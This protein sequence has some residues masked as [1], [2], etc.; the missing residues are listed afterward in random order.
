MAT[1]VTTDTL[2][3]LAGFR[4]GNGCAIS[5]TVDLDPSSTPTIPDV[6]TKFNSAIAQAEKLAEHTAGAEV[7]RRIHD[8]G[9]RIVVVAPEE[10]RGDLESALSKEAC[11]AIVGWATAEAHAGSNEL[12]EIV[13]PLLDEARARADQEALARFEELH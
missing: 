5:M 2:R 11:D 8:S 13:R 6:K 12:L 4:A 1:A 3:A 7:D 10:M 9:L